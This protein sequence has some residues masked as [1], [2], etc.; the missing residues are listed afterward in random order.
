MA[1]SQVA[2]EEKRRE[3]NRTE[4]SRK[5]PNERDKAKALCR[6]E[7]SL[8]R[9]TAL[10]VRLDARRTARGRGK[11]RQQVKKKR[12]RNSQEMRPYVAHLRP[13]L[14][15]CDYPIRVQRPLAQIVRA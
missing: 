14:P 13:R 4:E 15:V 1:F 2:K 3:Q 8:Q 6:A 7:D 5:L 10:S 11:G 12:N 9:Q